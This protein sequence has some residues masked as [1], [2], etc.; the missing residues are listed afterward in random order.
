MWY[1]SSVVK[2]PIPPERHF[3]KH[4]HFGA[5]EVEV[6]LVGSVETS[7]YRQREWPTLNP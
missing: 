1:H 3:D 5:N 6:G 7:C 2:L 4:A